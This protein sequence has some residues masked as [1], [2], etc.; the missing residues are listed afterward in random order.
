[1][2]QDRRLGFLHNPSVRREVASVIVLRVPARQNLL[3]HQQYSRRSCGEVTNRTKP[4]DNVADG[5][6]AAITIA[7]TRS[8]CQ[9]QAEKG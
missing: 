4:A 9:R 3:S 8:F 1:M 6:T 2:V 7:R 5:H